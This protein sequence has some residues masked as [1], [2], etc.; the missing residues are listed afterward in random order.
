M[1]VRFLGTGGPAGWPQPGCRCASCMRATAAGRVRQ[2][3]AVRVDGRLRLDPGQPP[4]GAAPGY[5]IE[6]VPGG[7]DITGPDGTRLLT[8]AGPGAAPAPL[9]ETG[10]FDLVLLDLLGSPAQLGALRERGLVGPATIAAAM[11]ADH[12]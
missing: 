12:R 3:G 1:D 6:P 10:P 5:R 2:P 4:R 9:A 8:A 7:W 11:Y